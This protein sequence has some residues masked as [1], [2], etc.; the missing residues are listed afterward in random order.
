MR[1]RFV[2]FVW[3]PCLQEAMLDEEVVADSDDDVQLVEEVMGKQTKVEVEGRITREAAGR[4]RAQTQ[5][6]L[7]VRTYSCSVSRYYAY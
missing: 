7:Q 3:N 2:D 1:H 4:G 5:G 6:L